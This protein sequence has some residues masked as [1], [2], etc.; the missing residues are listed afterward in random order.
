MIDD[1]IF[2]IRISLL[3]M[4]L[5]YR[6][7]YRFIADTVINMNT[8]SI[9]AEVNVGASSSSSQSGG[10]STSKCVSRLKLS[11]SRTTTKSS[12]GKSLRKLSST[13]PISSTNR[14]NYSHKTLIN[15]I[16]VI[17]TCRNNINHDELRVR[18]SIEELN[19][20]IKELQDKKLKEEKIL[21]EILDD[22]QFISRKLIQ[23]SLMEIHNTVDLDVKEDF[24]CP[25]CKAFIVSPSI[26]N[27]GHTF[28]T[29]CLDTYIKVATEEFDLLKCA[30][31]RTRFETPATNPKLGKLLSSM[32]QIYEIGDVGNADGADFKPNSDNN[33]D[34]NDSDYQVDYNDI[35]S[36]SDDD[37][38]PDIS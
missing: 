22:K 38:L 31:C 28:C 34:S 14:K 27:C 33:E 17:E 25:I 16:S 6:L 15:A 5:T 7:Y 36:D 12:C 37:S 26:L 3:F 18:E 32:A 24:L 4:H 8:R 13:I 30:V 20:Q 19:R 2:T 35:S 21:K 11:R 10:T 23:G 1:T 29:S 9:S